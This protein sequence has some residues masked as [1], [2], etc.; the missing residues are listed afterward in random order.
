MNNKR[1]MFTCEKCN[2]ET[3]FGFGIINLVCQQCGCYDIKFD[4]DVLV[5]P[6]LSGREKGEE[7]IVR[8][9]EPFYSFHSAGS[10]WGVSDVSIGTK[11]MEKD[12]REGPEEGT[13]EELVKPLL[14][15]S[16]EVINEPKTASE[17][18]VLLKPKRKV[19]N[20]LGI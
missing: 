5:H 1:I 3:K 8:S 20:T 18:P 15:K 17:K 7:L 12:I 2:R 4:S 19:R 13:V 9:E 10:I 16:E 11:P 14:E 6:I